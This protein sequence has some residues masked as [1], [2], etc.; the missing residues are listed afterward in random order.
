MAIINLVWTGATDLENAIV[1]Y[2]LSY[3]IGTSWIQIPF[4]STT[5]GYGSYSFTATQNVTHTFRIRTKDAA[6][7]YSPYKN[8]I[9]PFIETFNISETSNPTF[10]SACSLTTPNVVIY[11]S[12]S[13]LSNGSIVYADSLLTIP[14][15]GTRALIGSLSTG[16]SRQWKIL[17][18]QQENYS[19]RIDSMGVIANLSLCNNNVYNG[20]LSNPS[21]SGLGACVLVVQLSN[22]VYW[23]SSFFAVGTT[24]YSN[25]SMTNT[26]GA[27]WYRIYQI[28][29]ELERDCIIKVSAS[30][31][32]LTLN[33]YTPY[34]EVDSPGDSGNS[35]S[36]GGGCID[37]NTNILLMNNEYKLASDLNIGDIVHTLHEITNEYGNYEVVYK[38]IIQEEKMLIKFTDGTDITVS[39]SHK[40]LDVNYNWIDSY[41][42]V[43]GDILMGKNYDKIIKSINHIGSGDVVRL[44][45]L[46]A[47]TYIA[48]DLISHNKTI[49]IDPFGP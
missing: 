25:S 36:S 31:V 27:G 1:G 45:I 30:G 8:L 10:T 47:H 26:I 6:Q 37:P 11:P 28:Q 24:L 35:S 12:S 29:N 44:Q 2:D 49:V 7:N 18:P 4:I 40:F 23:S 32:I 33:N 14:F 43:D 5:N 34:C 13:V 16:I 21:T 42:L 20:L 19:V 9:V 15:D 3:K 39:S 38:D 41:M 46:N 17:T 48:N 22:S